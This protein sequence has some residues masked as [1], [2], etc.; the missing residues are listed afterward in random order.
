ML[1][2][3]MVPAVFGQIVREHVCRLSLLEKLCGARCFE[4]TTRMHSDSCFAVY[5]TVRERFPM[6][7]FVFAHE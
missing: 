5:D 4:R 2:R 1:R 6:V 7:L 3:R